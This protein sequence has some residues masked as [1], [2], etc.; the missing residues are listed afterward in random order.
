M[1]GIFRYLKQTRFARLTWESGSSS[2]LPGVNRFGTEKTMSEKYDGS[3]WVEKLRRIYNMKDQNGD[4]LILQEDFEEWG[5]RASKNIGAELSEEARLGWI[6]CYNLWFGE[7]KTF[8]AWKETILTMGEGPIEDIVAYGYTINE[9][10]FKTVDIDEDGTISWN[11]YKAFIM[12]LGATEAEAKVGFDM[13]D[14]N[15]DGVLSYEEFNHAMVMYYFDRN[16]S[17]YKHFYGE[18][19]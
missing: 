18:Y 16:N 15:S 2:P 19:K 3:F 4:G 17:K 14:T 8:E 6:N 10:I 13:I 11:E 12:P 1:S 5:E 7:H 9:P